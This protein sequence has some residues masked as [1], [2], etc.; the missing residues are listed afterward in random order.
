VQR[1][2]NPPLSFGNISFDKEP[3]LAGRLLVSYSASPSLRRLDQPHIKEHGRAGKIIACD[4]VSVVDDHILDK[5]QGQIQYIVVVEVQQF[6]ENLLNPGTV[7]RSL[8]LLGA[9][10]LS[11]LG[12]FGKPSPLYPPCLFFQFPDAPKK[13]HAHKSQKNREQP[14]CKQRQTQADQPAQEKQR[15]NLLRKV[16]FTPDYQRMKGSN[17]QQRGRSDCDPLK[18]QFHRSPSPA[19]DTTESGRQISRRIKP[20]ASNC[21]PWPGHEQSRHTGPVGRSVPHEFPA[22]QCARH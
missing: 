17:H 5:Q 12:I 10:V 22:G 15:P 1:Q 11:S 21:W 16:V 14:M 8:E 18:I 7:I 6:I 19:H 2:T 20:P 3:V 4:F 9:P 13:S